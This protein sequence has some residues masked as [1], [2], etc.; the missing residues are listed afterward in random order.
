MTVANGRQFLIRFFGTIG[1]A[2]LMTSL[3]GCTG[4]EG[5]KADSAKLASSA[6]SMANSGADT[7]GMIRRDS[8]ITLTPGH[9]PETLA[10][11]A[12]VG[13]R[14]DRPN[15]SRID[16]DVTC[17]SHGT[18][19]KSH[20]K[21]DAIDYSQTI[22]WDSVA[23]GTPTHFFARILVTNGDCGEYGLQANDTAYLSVGPDTTG[24]RM[25]AV[26]KQDPLGVEYKVRAASQSFCNYHVTIGINSGVHFN[27][28]R[29]TA[30]EPLVSTAPPFD[31]MPPAVGLVANATKPQVSCPTGCCQSYFASY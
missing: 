20:L 26:Y 4:N 18:T 27:D 30:P 15:Q 11:L 10:Y 13:A 1:A 28:P 6:D 5:T 31:P 9:N 14:W 22:R 8:G 19:N 17:H 23:T 29:C 21:I 3:A 25:V 12:R 2:I 7:T 16:N 24:A